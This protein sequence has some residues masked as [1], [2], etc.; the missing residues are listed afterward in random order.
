AAGPAAAA[1]PADVALCPD[2]AREILD[3]RDRRYQYPFT[4]CTN[5][6]PRFTIIR[7]LPYD[8]AQTTMAA[9]VMC[10]D[11]LRE[12]QE[13]LNRRF[14][15]E[16]TACPVCGPHLWLE[17]AGQRWEREALQKTGELL[18]AGQIVAI[19]GLGG[20]HLA[21]DAANE[22]AVARLRQRK[23][24]RDKPFAV[25]VR[26][27]AIAAE[28]AE[29]TAS[30]QELLL[31]PASPI[32]LARRR[33]EAELAAGLAPGNN[34][35]GLMLPYTPLHLLLFQWAPPVLVMTSG[36]RSEEPLAFDNDEAKRTL[37]SLADAF[38]LHNRDIQVPCDDSVLRPV[39]GQAPIILRRARGYVPG[40]LA[41]PVAC[42]ETI[43]GVGAQDKNTFCLAWEQTAVLSQHIG[44]LDSSET[45]DY[46][47]LAIDHLACLCQRRPSL[48]AHDLHPEYLSS[49]YAQELA[50][51]RRLGVQHHHAHL[52]ACLAEHGRGGPCLGLAFDGTGYGPDG[53][54][55]GGE[56]L[57]AELGR[58]RRLGH[59]QPLVLPGGEAAIRQPTRMAFAYLQAAFG[60]AADTKA[61]A[62]GLQLPPLATQILR[63]QLSTGWQS[64]LTTS[65]GRLFDALA[66]AL[67]IC[68]HRTYEGQPALELE[69]A[70]E[71]G[72]DG[73]YE[74]AILQQDDALLLDNIGLFR[75]AVADYLQGTP[76]ECVAAR[77]HT[78]LAQ[79]AAQLCLTA[80][81][82]TGLNLVA[83]SG[84]VWQNSLLLSR[85]LARL[86]EA[87]FEV[88]TH[89]RVP[90]NDGCIALGQ[91]AVAA[92]LGDKTG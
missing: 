57:L 47:R 77:F 91:A 86:T 71:K 73:C 9:F 65:V 51:V 38:L 42:R 87:G 28:I 20:F 26:D 61:A 64:P 54:I 66:A 39:P 24:R 4:N 8:R 27:L 15:A 17:W 74:V 29:L 1:I 75:Q 10:P 21:C 44:D 16:P 68:R 12:Y 56:L 35:L 63:R 5:C 33:C 40:T 36:N 30:A 2:C 14:H 83:L 90:P 7:S 23:G 79:A 18:Q 48:V 76:R 41:L 84:G 62:L 43:L 60:E 70:A 6:G 82:Q 67:D 53:T 13:P 72:D 50:D 59:L 80:R 55:W 45:F 25:M 22:A 81:E 32:V 58:Y 69:M 34:Y 37:V 88:L 46:F 92:A 3:P 78:S 19:K 89:R 31:S 52:A 11:C 49:R 85:C